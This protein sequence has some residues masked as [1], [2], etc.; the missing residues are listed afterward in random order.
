[1]TRTLVPWITLAAA[2]ALVLAGCS[3]GAPPA[4]EPVDPGSERQPDPGDQPTDCIV[5]TWELIVPEY[6]IQAESYLL[7]LGIPVEGF[8]MDGAQVLTLTED[9]LLLVET[10]LTSSGTLVTESL[11]FPFSVTTTESAT[12]EWGWNASDLA[13]DGEI[14]IAEYRVVESQTESAEEA[15]EAG[16]EP[17]VPALGDEAILG[18]DCDAQNLLLQGSGPL[19][20][21]WARR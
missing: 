5:G 3:T 13:G 16:V 11:E 6:A 12:A 14:E 15:A 19:T 10:D 4:P 17:P 7:G 18:V 21:V 1:M 20:A 2:A 9:G 8:G